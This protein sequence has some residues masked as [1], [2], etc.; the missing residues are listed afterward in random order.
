MVAIVNWMDNIVD[1]AL[2]REIVMP[3][4]HD[5][6]VWATNVLKTN[7]LMDVSSIA[8]QCGDIDQQAQAGSRWFDIRM[9]KTPTR[10]APWEPSMRPTPL[11]GQKV[12]MRAAHVPTFQEG[13]ITKG[14]LQSP[15]IGGYGAS[16]E[17]ILDQALRFVSLPATASE[18]IVLRFSHC[19]E[20]KKVLKEIKYYIDDQTKANNIG[21]ILRHTTPNRGNN[22][23]L[24]PMAALRGKVAMIFDDLF[25]KHTADN[26]YSDWMFT[27]SKGH[28]ANAADAVCCGEYPNSMD[29]NVV[30]TAAVDAATAHLQHGV[31]DGHLCFIYWQL[32]QRDIGKQMTGGGNIKAFTTGA[33]GTH[34]ATDNLMTTLAALLPKSGMA[35]NQAGQFVAANVISHDFV[36]PNVSQMIVKHNNTPK[37]K[38]LWP[39]TW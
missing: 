27:Y 8:A 11:G 13:M 32:T 36:H 7:A 6:G 37:I 3:G 33:T 18:F 21:R 35:R 1:T 34:L 5:A 23:G 28:D 17:Q 31:V 39:P 16:I 12:M 30:K 25:H 24:T 2:L 38:A 4:S 20:P 9:Y 19:P 22:L 14:I 10:W 26:N 29:L 15:G